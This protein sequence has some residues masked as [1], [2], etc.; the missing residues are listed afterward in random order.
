MTFPENDE[1]FSEYKITEV[2]PQ[3]GPK[4]SERMWNVGFDDGFYIGLPVVDDGPAPTVGDT[5]RLYGQGLGYAVR[6]AFFN[7]VKLFYR[8]A[9]EQEA[10][11][12]EQQ[13]KAKA[14]QK[15]EYDKKAEEYEQRIKALPER[16]QTRIAG[17]R[18]RNDTFWEFLPY[19]LFCC[20]EAVAIAA[21]FDTPEEV[22]AF[23]KLPVEE[24]KAKVPEM[25]MSEH[26][27]NTFGF[28]CQL[29]KFLII[30][31]PDFVEN[32]HGAL[33]ALTGCEDYGCWAMT[34]QLEE[35]A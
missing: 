28:S 33:C 26:S 12:K 17:F 18:E 15:A 2:N 25:Q 13:E 16:L 20:E 32:Y 8:T 5:C 4:H 22:D 27:G 24:Q 30:D 14:A 6:G 1:Q 3:E 21:K 31:E 10:F 23:Y 11:Q 34:Q 9:V 35:G 29:A 7:G 19:E